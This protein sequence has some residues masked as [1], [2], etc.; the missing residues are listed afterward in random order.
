MNNTFLNTL[1]IAFL[2][3]FS[4]FY[5]SCD[6]KVDDPIKPNEEEL[7]TTVQL[8]FTDTSNSN[9]VRVF[10]F[11]DTDGEGGNPPSQFDTIKLNANTTYK[12]DVQ[13]IDESKTPVEDI[14][15]EV[16]EEAVEH[17]V[18]YTSG[19]GVTIAITDKDVNMLELGLEALVTTTITGNTSLSIS[20][21]HQPD[22]KD[23][24]CSVGETDVEVDFP[25]VIQ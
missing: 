12:L 10:K 23:G 13:F 11:S 19:G 25:F 2:I 3:G 14:T 5:T 21:K 15:E 18:C 8:T 4:F 16:R 22:I 24:S 6:D 7:I 20:L 17:L 1:T 9:D